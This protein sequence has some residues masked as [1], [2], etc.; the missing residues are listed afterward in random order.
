VALLGKHGGHRLQASDGE[1]ASHAKVQATGT[2]MQGAMEH[3][4]LDA[5]PIADFAGGR[6]ASK[7]SLEGKRG[8]ASQPG[9]PVRGVSNQGQNPLGGRNDDRSPVRPNLNQGKGAGAGPWRL[10][11]R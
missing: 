5:L 9:K 3:P 1:V 10:R 7:L 2:A 8:E 6:V 4:G 11:A